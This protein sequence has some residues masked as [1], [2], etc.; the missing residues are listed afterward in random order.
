[1]S[2]PEPALSFRPSSPAEAEFLYRV[3]A[4][5]RLE[6]LEITGWSDAEKEAFLRQQFH[7]QDVHYRKHHPTTAFDLI[8]A[9]GELIG[10]LYVE[11]TP[12]R[13]AILD[14]ALLPAWRGQGLGSRILRDLLI[15]ARAAGQCVQLFVEAFN[16]ARRLYARLGFEKVGDC[17]PY[18]ELH[19]R[20][21]PTAE[22]GPK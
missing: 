3:Y 20:P 13:L 8:L 2:R 16:P 21:P 1:M 18:E 5:T 12:D 22:T 6:E 7:F 11:R 10:R 15:E 9:D 19:L 17:G 4:S 14:I